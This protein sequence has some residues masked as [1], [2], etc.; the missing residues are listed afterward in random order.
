MLQPPLRRWFRRDICAALL[1]KTLLLAG[2]YCLYAGT[3]HKPKV[4]ASATASVL[5]GAADTR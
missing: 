4:D 5:L 3:A 2:I 1:L